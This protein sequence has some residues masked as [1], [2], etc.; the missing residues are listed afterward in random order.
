MKFTPFRIF[1]SVVSACLS[2]LFF[3]SSATAQ[4]REWRPIAA[5]DIAAKQPTVEADA[6]AEALFWEM[7][8]DDASS[9]LEM[10]HYV[11]VKIF[12]ERGRE[13]FSKFDIP[14]TKGIK[15]KNLT[16]RVIKA[17]GSIV[18]IT[19]KDI[20]EREIIRVSG[21][22]VKAKSFAVPNIEPGVIVEYKYK[23]DIDDGGAAGMRLQLQRD[24]PVRTLSYYYKPNT[25]GEPKY[26]AYNISDFKFKEHQKGFWLAERKN[27]PAF[28]EEPRMPPEDMVRPWLQLTSARLAITSMSG[29]GFSFVIKD[30][31]NVQGYWSAFA[32]QRAETMKFILK[33]D[34]AVKAA[35]E[36]I[37]AGAVSTDEKLKRLYEF[38]QKDIKNVFYDPKITSEQRRK[39]APIKSMADILKR[40]E[41]PVPGY[42]DWLFASLAGSLGMD[43]KMAFT[44]NKSRVFFTPTMTND[45][46][47]HAAGIAVTEGEII[48]YFNPGDPFMPYNML[49]WY[50]EGTPA[51]LVGEKNYRWTDTPAAS[52][53]DNNYKRTAK[54][55]LSEDG[56]LEGDISVE[57]TGQPAIIYRQTYHD[58]TDEKRT[59][60]ISES[61]KQRISAA[62]VSSITV[63]NLLDPTKPIHQRYKIRVP[64]FAQKTGKRMFVQPGFF[65]SGPAALFSSGTRKY[66]V[67]FSYPWSEDDNV[68]IKLPKT[69]DLDNLEQPAPFSDPSKIGSVQV[70]M[71]FDP[72]NHNLTYGRKFYFGRGNKL[73]FPAR[74]YPALKNVFDGFHKTD[75]QT[76]SLKQK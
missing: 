65:E 59:E 71:K 22:K 67:F 40:R 73:L 32:S 21:I 9:D 61:V 60:G 5:E 39:M 27:V 3:A 28:K 7:Q 76:I 36:R 72:A 51:I 18:E 6:D 37:T 17:D 10:W 75:S 46:L 50:E 70:E 33:P 54:L 25:K 20:F 24:I 52:H 64:N 41:A 31:S 13:K 58:E 68:E 30:P 55:V 63:D 44:G 14:F 19:D 15:I 56:T 69:F 2:C 53:L 34:K 66:D 12:T 4:Y 1:L 29:Y 49:S 8:I 35:A 43:V 38:C 45:S 48:R 47:V 42:I 16:A 26:Q 62:E 57:M 23:E 74:V 11:R